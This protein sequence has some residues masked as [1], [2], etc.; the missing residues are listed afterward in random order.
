VP[1]LSRKRKK[2]FVFDESSA[3][4]RAIRNLVSSLIL[5]REESEVVLITSSVHGEGKT[6]VSLNMAAQFAES[7]DQTL[8]IDG[9]LDNPDLTDVLDL[10]GTP[11]LSELVAGE[12]AL[13]TG[14]SVLGEL[15][16]DAIGAGA[17]ANLKPAG[18]FSSNTCKSLLR[19]AKSL[20]DVVLIDA[21]GVAVSKDFLHFADEIDRIVLVVAPEIV[22]KSQLRH[23]R[24][25]LGGVWEGNIS[26]L[27]NRY[28]E[29][30][31][32]FLS[33]LIWNKG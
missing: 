21:S 13:S 5:E 30:I 6:T 31:P 22:T 27:L 33:S 7:G 1:K 19:E 4:S 11:G 28:K 8:L 2:A 9:A 25:E 3:A 32:Y 16:I 24:S 14:I 23:T 17:D 12:Q 15:R 26:V 10:G 18:I 29:P 20:Y